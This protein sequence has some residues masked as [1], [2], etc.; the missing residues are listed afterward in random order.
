MEKKTL[1]RLTLKNPRARQLAC[2]LSRITGE[3]LTATVI[4]ALEKRL[5][6]ERKRADGGRTAEKILAFSEWFASG[7]KPGSG[8]ADH[9]ESHGDDGMPR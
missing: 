8:S 5:A 4:S 9:A 2:D 6:A 1:R 7:M 3:S